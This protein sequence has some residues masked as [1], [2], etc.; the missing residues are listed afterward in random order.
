MVWI[1]RTAPCLVVKTLCLLLLG[2]CTGTRAVPLKDCSLNG[3]SKTSKHNTIEKCFSEL[4]EQIFQ[5]FANLNLEDK[6]EDVKHG[7]LRLQ[8]GSSPNEGMLQ[9]LHEK[10]WG[11]VCFNNWTSENSDVACRHLGYASAE[12]S[13]AMT[14]RSEKIPLRKIYLEGVRCNGSE[15]SLWECENARVADYSSSCNP[16]HVV[17]L[18]CTRDEGPTDQDTTESVPLDP[19]IE[20][21]P[22]AG[23]VTSTSVSLEWENWFAVAQ[24][25]L[26]EELVVNFRIMYRPAGTSENF[27]MGALIPG[28]LKY[29]TVDGLTERTPYEFKVEAWRLNFKPAGE[30][31]G[32]VSPLVTVTT[33]CN[34]PRPV[35]RVMADPGFP[36]QL[37]VTW[38]IGVDEDCPAESFVVEY[39]LLNR[40]QCQD[41]SEGGLDGTIRTDTAPVLLNNLHPYSTYMVNVTVVNIYGRSTEKQTMVNTSEGAPTDPPTSI[42]TE[43]HASQDALVAMWKAPPCGHRNGRITGYTYMLLDVQTDRVIHSG[44]TQL[45]IVNLPNV[46]PLKKYKFLVAARTVTGMGPYGASS[47]AG[48]LNIA[49]ICGEV[50]PLATTRIVGGKQTVKGAF[51]WMAQIW[52]VKYGRKYC[53]GSIL[54]DHWIITAAHCIKFYNVTTRDIMIQVGD[55]DTLLPEPQQRVYDVDRIYVHPGFDADT[56]DNDIALIRV[57]EP[58]EF[59]D[60]I[61][62]ICL[63]DKKSSRSL[64][65][66]GVERY[67]V[68]AGWGDDRNGAAPRYLKQI[69]LP[70]VDRAECKRST[71]YSFTPNMFC[72]GFATAMSGD[73]CKGDS[74]APFMVRRN[75]KEFI[76]GIVSWGSPD[77]CDTANQYGYY[78]RIFKFMSWIKRVH[79]GV[80]ILKRT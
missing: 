21:P 44:S 80:T 40:E 17:W 73:T 6:R 34:G 71:N 15:S 56:Y 29:G 64:I 48:Q 14:G 39:K 28:Y 52:H 30:V 10:F 46:D 49:D 36:H 24:S 4:R 66:P 74:G 68:V 55:Y 25:V 1:T 50:H 9:V 33:P 78:T 3:I 61:K 7:R 70:I 41:E 16:R 75:G 31:I 57:R 2:F 69:T 63:P 26:P 42:S 18:S 38:R 59:S 20:P 35:E 45:T 19:S 53:S 11:L 62:P 37:T 60:Y 12:R 51:P 54:D 8:Q 27:T 76:T 65:K 32:V 5:L 77:G 43:Y 23:R 22:V 13:T 79:P 72:A 67:G 47:V 58:I